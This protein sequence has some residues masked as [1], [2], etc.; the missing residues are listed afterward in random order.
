VKPPADSRQRQIATR[1]PRRPG[2]TPIVAISGA[3]GAGKTRLI[4]RLLRLLRRRGLKV[5]VLKHTGHRH[6]FDV[7]GKDTDLFLRAGAV[8]AAIQGP[9][10][11]AFFGPPR[12]GARAL[13]RLLPPCDLIL[14]EGWRGEPL[15]RVEV[16]RRR[17]ER[18]FLCATDRRVFALVSDEPPPRPLPVFDPDRLGPLADLLVDRLAGPGGWRRRA[19]PPS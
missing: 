8:A 4:T 10:G 6:G 2:P 11:L 12:D 9:E 17:V 5:A 16:H 14:A 7:P 19:R 15:P 13:A 3:S 1:S 18:E